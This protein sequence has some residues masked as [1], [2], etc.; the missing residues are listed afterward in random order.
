VATLTI[1]PRDGARPGEAVIT[2]TIQGA[3]ASARG[4]LFAIRRPGYAAGENLG[5]DGWQVP[6]AQ[7]A[8]SDARPTERGIE[9]L[10]GPS[11]VQHMQ[12]GNYE[13]VLS[14][15]GLAAPIIGKFTWRNVRPFVPAARGALPPGS[16][17]GTTRRRA[18]RLGVGSGGES[19]EPARGDNPSLAW[20]TAAPPAAR[21]PAGEVPAAKPPEP[22]PAPPKPAPP[23]PVPPKVEP[24]VVP[25]APAPIPVAK[26]EPIPA[27]PPVMTEAEKERERQ[28]QAVIAAQAAS[29]ALE[30][31]RQLDLDGGGRKRRGGGLIIGIVVVVILLLLVGGAVAI[32]MTAPEPITALDAARQFLESKPPPG[33]QAICS[34]A[35]EFQKLGAIDAAAP[36]FRRAADTG[37]G[38][39]AHGLARLYD[40]TDFAAGATAGIQCGAA[41]PAASGSS[42][43]WYAGP[44]A[45]IR[46]LLGAPTGA[47]PPDLSKPRSEQFPK[48]NGRFAGTWYERA[49]ADGDKEAKADLDNLIKWAKD[50]AAKGDEDAA[51]VLQEFNK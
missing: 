21:D 29:A 36:L 6:E 4:V 30:A 45:K 27:P 7:L 16:P 42:D 13:F 34:A 31:R 39:A 5:P 20:P 37:F 8:P 17:L 43:P 23:K 3:T 41:G 25:V 2:V 12:Q 18:G 28:Q 51:T 49:I 15:G 35:V 11:V 47:P 40:P 22:P 14:G 44:I 46:A 48:S 50:A 38:P 32:R 24:P 19:G 9:L 1:E 26:P 10:V 33:P